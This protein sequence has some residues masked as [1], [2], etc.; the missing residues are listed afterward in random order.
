MDASDTPGDRGLLPQ[1][2]I[3]A[4]LRGN[5]LRRL[6]SRVVEKSRPIGKVARDLGLNGSS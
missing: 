6:R 1:A 2:Y 3:V 5:P 4:P